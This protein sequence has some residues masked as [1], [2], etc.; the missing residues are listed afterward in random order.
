MPE[1]ISRHHN[2]I[3]KRYADSA[4]NNISVIHRNNNIVFGKTKSGFI[5][6]INLKIIPIYHA[7]KDE[8]EFLGILR[9]NKIFKNQA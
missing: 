4:E 2:D 5:F 3:L 9:R 8:T 1:I 6:P 7:V